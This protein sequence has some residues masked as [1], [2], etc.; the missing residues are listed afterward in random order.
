MNNIEFRNHF[1]SMVSHSI[2]SSH[3][4]DEVPLSAL[5]S[6]EYLDKQLCEHLGIDFTTAP[7]WEND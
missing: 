3:D 7:D 1:M 2:T 5:Q 6:I 4:S